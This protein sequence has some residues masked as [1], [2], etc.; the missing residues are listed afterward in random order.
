MK[1]VQFS[2]FGPPEQ[3]AECIEA[4]DPPAPADDEV[5]L[6]VLAFPINPADTLMIEGRYA[7]RP[8]L[9]ARVGAECMARVAAVG[10]AVARS[11]RPATW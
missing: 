1:I 8:A 7:M 10:S 5:A 3:V 11:A 4:D 2:R 6:E 9:P